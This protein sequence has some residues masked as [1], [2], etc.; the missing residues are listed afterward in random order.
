MSGGLKLLHSKVRHLGTEENLKILTKIYLDLE[1]KTKIIPNGVRIIGRCAIC[2]HNEVEL[3][4]LPNS[5]VALAENAIS[6]CKNL[7]AIIFEG[8]TSVIEPTAIVSCENLKAIFVPSGQL[9]YYQSKLSQQLSDLLIELEDTSISEEEILHN[10][11]VLEDKKKS[12]ANASE[13][14]NI[15]APSKE[16]LE[17]S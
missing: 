3:I 8:K 13:K 11:F 2:G 16:D 15:L 9:N 12:I 4:K 1:K 10:I 6:A 5:I 14:N 17:V 7:T